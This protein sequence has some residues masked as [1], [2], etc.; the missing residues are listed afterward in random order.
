MRKLEIKNFPPL[1]YACNEAVNT[2]CTNLSFAGSDVKKIMITSCHAAEGKTFLSMNIMRMLAKFG[3]TVVLV[4]ADL[5][6]SIISA[7]YRLQYENLEEKWGL[8]HMLAGMVDEDQIIYQTSV[9][10]AYMVPVGREVSNPLPLLN[11]PRFAWLLD[12]LAQQVDYVLIDAP[13]VGLVI[14]AAQ[15]AKNCD[16]SII[17]VNY[18]SVR[19]QELI[20]V[21]EQL[22]QTGCPILGTVLNMVEYD[23][24]LSKKYY[25]R[26]YYSKYERYE[27]TPRQR[28]KAQSN[29]TN[30]KMIYK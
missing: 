2:L 14:D 3:K 12:H 1:G 8:S 27:M 25:Y 24:Y 17:V 10:G 21:K 13:P 5:R 22:E 16:G 20:D 18:N 6:R 9:P 19:R 7:T 23:S 29:Q 30:R 11:S 4:D 26:S 15:I 28:R